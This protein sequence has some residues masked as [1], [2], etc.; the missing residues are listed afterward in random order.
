MP[1][2][3]SKPTSKSIQADGRLFGKLL[4]QQEDG[5]AGARLVAKSEA[6]AE[7]IL[8]AQPETMADVVVQ[9]TLAASL[10]EEALELESDGNEARALDRCHTLERILLDGAKIIARTANFDLSTIGRT[11]RA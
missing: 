5:A 2:R 11:A 9:L 8:A 3:R 10:P 6:V 4:D 1:N 7:R